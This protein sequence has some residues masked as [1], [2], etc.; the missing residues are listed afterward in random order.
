ME[1]LSKEITNTPYSIESKFILSTKNSTIKANDL[2]YIENRSWKGKISWLIGIAL[3]LLILPIL[4]LVKENKLLWFFILGS[5]GLITIL[6]GFIAPKKRMIYD[7]MKGIITVAR[8][9]FYKSKKIPF[10]IGYATKIYYTATEGLVNSHL[11]FIS[12]KKKPRIG[13]ILSEHHL[14]EFWNFTVWYMDKN[15]PLP[16]GTAFDEYRQR[17]FE[18]RKAKGFPKPLYPSNIS[19][20]EATKEQQAERKRIGGW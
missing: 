14:E 4:F 18:R 11:S 2:Y 16:P 10:S 6:Y 15:R 20:L 5:P 13:G 1:F 7:R 3:I 19:T 17:D 12:S 8:P 9:H